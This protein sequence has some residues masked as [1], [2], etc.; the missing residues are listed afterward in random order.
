MGYCLRLCS[1]K[2]GPKRFR[3]SQIKGSGESRMQ[4]KKEM[5]KDMVSAEL[6][7]SLIPQRSLKYELYH[8]L[9]ALLMQEG[10]PLVHWVSGHRMWAV[11]VL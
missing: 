2:A 6:S 4:Q 7:S 1:I 10:R 8:R 5:S 11:I 3:C 9:G